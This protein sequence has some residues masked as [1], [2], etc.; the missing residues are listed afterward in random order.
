MPEIAPI[1]AQSHGSIQFVVDAVEPYQSSFELVAAQAQ[2][3]TRIKRQLIQT[4]HDPAQLLVKTNTDNPLIQTIHLAFSQHYPLVL[5]PDCLWLTIAQGFANHVNRHA[6]HLR[7]RFVAHEAKKQ[8]TI[9][10][11]D[12]SSQAAWTQAIELWAAFLNQALPDQL[13]QTLQCDF[14]TTTSISRTASQIGLMERFEHYFDYGAVCVCGIP[15]ITLLGTPADWRSIAERVER[16]AEYDLAWWTERIAPICEGLILTSE[17][18]PPHSFWQQLYKPYDQYGGE[19][20]T[21]WVA[22]LFPY[23]KDTKEQPTLRNPLFEQPRSSLLNAELDHELD[24]P[25][26]P[27]IYQERLIQY[28]FELPAESDATPSKSLGEGI[29]N[30]RFPSGLARVPITI[31]LPDGSNQALACVAGLIGTHYDSAKQQLSPEIGWAVC[32]R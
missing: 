14:S 23:I 25:Y 4:S 3:A 31:E 27:A 20:V 2:F 13:A 22:D 1:L 18:R 15:N 16:L 29:A 17:G 9:R 10:V 21:G 32:Q 6:E 28:L 19:V 8:L 12:L 5:T 30:H 26:N 11:D 24:W 7:Q